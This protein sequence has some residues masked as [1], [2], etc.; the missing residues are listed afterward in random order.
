MLINL[1]P[2]KSS[3][4][5][6]LSAIKHRYFTENI[7]VY[8]PSMVRRFLR[9][10]IPFEKYDLTDIKTALKNV[11]ILSE[12]LFSK[13]I[14]I[15]NKLLTTDE[16]FIIHFDK[17]EPI[18]SEWPKDIF[19]SDDLISS[20]LFPSMRGDINMFILDQL[21][22]VKSFG[23]CYIHSSE[24]PIVIEIDETKFDQVICAL[25]LIKYNENQPS[26]LHFMKIRCI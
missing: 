12:D 8:L 11:D 6:E 24:R 18:L 5:R 20:L 14:I 15:L 4:F 23:L 7:P 21:K 19:T 17:N 25:L 2:V 13:L 1:S 16:P 26:P 10:A 3:F 22:F 9:E